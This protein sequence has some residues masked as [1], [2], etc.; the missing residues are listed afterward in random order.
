MWSIGHNMEQRLLR[1]GITKIG[2]IANN[3]TPE[4][5]QE[6]FGVIGVEMWYHVNGIDM[7]LIQDKYKI[8]RKSKSLGNGQVLFRDYYYPEINQI[9]LEMVDVVCARC[10]ATNQTTQLVSV[11]I[12]Y[13]KDQLGGFSRQMKLNSPTTSAKLIFEMVMVLFKKN[14]TP[15]TPIRRVNI[16]LGLLADRREITYGLFDNVSEYIDEENVENTI[17]KIRAKFGNNSIIRLS[18]ESKH[19]TYKQRN[20]MIGGHNSGQIS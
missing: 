14:Y 16:S 20:Q 7:S 15:N 8:E 5:F 6:I 10:R 13:S 17:D 19:S 12:M 11:G 4:Q 3:F 2:D 1:L 18:S 9:L